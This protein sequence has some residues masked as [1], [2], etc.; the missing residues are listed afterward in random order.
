VDVRTYKYNASI[1]TDWCVGFT[2]HKQSTKSHETYKRG[3]AAVLSNEYEQSLLEGWEEVHKKGQLTLWI[4]LALK[5][6]PKYMAEIKGFIENETNGSLSADDKSMYRA[7]RRYY[8]TE[9]VDFKSEPGQGGPDRK[10]YRLTRIGH[11]VLHE[12][13]QRNITNMFYRPKI[14]ELIE[15]KDYHEQ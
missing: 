8:E 1:I 4:M 12:F 13:V 10:V 14:K 5:D 2:A 9:L 6:G 11:H 7:L 3:I 15:R